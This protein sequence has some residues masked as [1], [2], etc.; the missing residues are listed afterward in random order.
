MY[1]LSH[2]W[3]H[4]CLLPGFWM[5]KGKPWKTAGKTEKG[6]RE[7]NLCWSEI[8]VWK[9]LKSFWAAESM[10][11]REGITNYTWIKGA[12][13]KDIIS[14]E[15]KEAKRQREALF[16]NWSVK[17]ERCQ[18]RKYRVPGDKEDPPAFPSPPK[19]QT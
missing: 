17:K 15:E 10:N 6:I 16:S 4:L 7:G 9:I 11:Y 5:S 2:F 1:D 12:F 19:K 8:I 13:L 14:G 3:P 18:R